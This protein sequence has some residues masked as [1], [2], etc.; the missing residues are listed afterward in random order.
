MSPPFHA[1]P[2][3]RRWQAA[4]LAA[5]TVLAC[6]AGAA[7]EPAA[8]APQSLPDVTVVAVAHR[9]GRPLDDVAPTVSLITRR[10]I[11]TGLAFDLRDMLRYEPGLAIDNNPARFGLGNL[12]IRGIDG[13]RVQLLLDG[14]RL[15]ESYRVGSF[16]NATRDALGLGLLQKVEI[17]RGPGS[18]LYGSDALAGVLAF[19]TVDPQDIVRAGSR[20]GLTLDLAG[21]TADDSLHRGFVLATRGDVEALVGYQRS[22]G[23]ERD[24]RGTVDVVGTSR[25]TPNPQ[26][27]SAETWLGKLVLPTRAARYRLTLDRARRAATTQVLSLNPQ[28]SR[29]V[30]LDGD[31]ESTRE[32]TSLDV[33]ADGGGAGVGPF[34]RLRA[35]L[36]TQRALTLNDTLD[37]RA[38]T[39]AA[40]LSA[41][42]TVTCLRDVR[43]RYVQKENG[44][45][46]LADL[47]GGGRWVFGLEAARVDTDEKRDG[48]QTDLG[49]GAVSKTVGGEPLPTRDFPLSRT[50]RFGA[51]VQDEIDWDGARMTVIPAVRYD[52]FAVKP[53][54]DAVFAAGNPGRP[55]VEL[56]DDAVSPKLGLLWRPAAGTTVSAQ[57]ATGFRAPAAA[58]IN[59]GLTNLPAGY[60]VIPNPDLKS[61]RSRGAELGVRARLGR[62]HVTATVFRT[63]YR[64]LIVSRAPLA[65]PADPR[66]VPGA[67]GTF[68]SQNITRARIQGFEATALARLAPAWAL[69]ASY[70]EA[71]GED[72]DRDVPLNSVE[73]QR[74]ATGLLYE[75]DH[76]NAG[77]HLV[78]AWKKTR[79]D[80]STGPYTPA[81]GYTTLDLTAEWVFGRD[82]RISAGVFNVFDKK[83]WLWSDLRVAPRPGNTVDRYTQPGRTASVLLRVNL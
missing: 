72:V 18:A 55:V 79:I 65:C 42:G 46:L 68:Q 35:L 61:E 31:D 49:T 8:G 54:I 34:V 32:R 56:R 39:T 10:D 44:A 80:Q 26:D 82:V 60:T 50:D 62:H 4:G 45:S 59:I 40:C 58:D 30:Q 16:S 13:N 37:L 64:D 63:D 14:I 24:N 3:A 21:S 41:V 53:E 9:S 7:Q 83:Y 57:W 43:F 66:C 77:A 11:E 51:F 17:L 76:L 19:H 28:S 73:P 78:R 1:R 33:D 20:W 6:G 2:A 48:Q 5:S 15:P 23:H 75:T 12:S 27:R 29:T 25:T 81:P 52:R 47:E 69:R 38:N 67:T 70:A 36:Y 22:D 71:R 74:L